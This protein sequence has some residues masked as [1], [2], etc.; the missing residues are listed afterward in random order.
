MKNIFS[1]VARTSNIQL[2]IL[3]LECAIQFNMVDEVHIWNYTSNV[4][5]EKYIRSIC[6]VQRTTSTSNGKYIQANMEI[7]NNH[8]TF[9]VI[10]KNDVHL[11]FLYNNCEYEIMLGA[12]SNTRS[13]LSINRIHKCIVY[14]SDIVNPFEKTKIEVY[15]ENSLQIHVKINGRLFMCADCPTSSISCPSS[16]ITDIYV[17]TGFGS[18]GYFYYKTI[19][20]S[21]FYFMDTCDK[22]T[23]NDMYYH[24]SITEHADDVIL[25]CYND[26]AFIDLLKLPAFIEYVRSNNLYKI[27]FPSVITN[28]LSL[29]YMQNKYDLIDKSVICIDYPENGYIFDSG[30][31]ADILHDY[32]LKKYSSFLNYD[33]GN[34]VIPINTFFDLH[35]FAYKGINWIQI[36]KYDDTSVN[37]AERTYSSGLYTGLCVSYVKNSTK[38]YSGVDVWINTSKWGPKYMDLYKKLINTRFSGQKEIYP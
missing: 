27:V 16:T 5:D 36:I 2:L 28:C 33:Y 14:Q 9:Y 10:A 1:V 25:T 19:S 31:I 20:H 37:D 13:I 6:N 29:Y 26:I 35:F 22:H 7:L 8:I 34:D 4:E 11:K 18:V 3:Y 24:Y 32:F 23:F 17:K 12:Y 38:I 30:P 15:V 21:H